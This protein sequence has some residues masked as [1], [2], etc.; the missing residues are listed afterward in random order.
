MNKQDRI[1]WSR[2]ANSTD[3]NKELAGQMIMQYEENGD[4]DTLERCFRTWMEK[5]FMDIINTA[6]KTINA[7]DNV[8]SWY[9]VNHFS[10]MIGH[11]IVPDT[12]RA[13]KASA[14]K[15]VFPVGQTIELYKIVE[16]NLDKEFTVEDAKPF[17]DPCIWCYE[18]STIGEEIGDFPFL[19]NYRL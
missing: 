8:K 11:N 9:K 13:M 15:I 18:E 4:Y 19:L 3:V 14:I 5:M 17:T 2:L 10:V 1:K 16:F 6:R 7:G 12:N